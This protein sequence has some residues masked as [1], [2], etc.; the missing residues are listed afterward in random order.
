MMIADLI[1]KE[2]L[3]QYKIIDAPENHASELRFKLQ[4]ALRLGNEFKSK[5]SITVQTDAGPKRFETTV[6]SLSDK[7][8]QIKNGILIPLSSLIDIDYWAGSSEVAYASRRSTA[9]TLD[10]PGSTMVTP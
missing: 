9:T 8:L 6:W 7:Y 3:Y 5:A 10:T 4:N 1:E 2:D